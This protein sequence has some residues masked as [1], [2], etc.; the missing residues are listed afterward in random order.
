MTASGI[1]RTYRDV[2]V[3]SVMRRKVDVGPT[4]RNFSA[5][6]VGSVKEARKR[7]VRV[8]SVKALRVVVLTGGNI[9]RPVRRLNVCN[10]LW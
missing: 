10:Y 7:N 6:V 2:G 4:N 5:T 3:E 1:F 8:L 9:V